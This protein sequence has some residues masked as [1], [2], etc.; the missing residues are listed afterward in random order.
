[1]KRILLQII[2]A[3]GV[4]LFSSCS[5]EP[6]LI[7]MGLD[8]VYYLPRMKAYTLSPAFTGE[9]YRW[10]LKTSSGRD[11]L[12][13]TE[14][15]Y[16]F[17]QAEEGTYH[18]TFEL[19]DP[20]F[21]DRHEF[22]VV[23]LHEEVEYSPYISRV[24][25][26][27]PAPGQ[28]VNLMPPYE[29]RDTEADMRRKAEEYISGNWKERNEDNEEVEK[30][31]VSLGG[32][33]GYITF[34]FDHTVVNVKGEKDFMIAGNA[35]YDLQGSTVTGGSAEPGIVKVAFDKNRN[36]IPD[37]DEWYELAGSEYHNSATLKNY[38]IIYSRPDPNKK[39]VPG[40]GMIDAEYIAWKDNRGAAGYIPQNI[41]HAQDY[42]PQWIQEEQLVCSGT[43]L[44]PNG[45]L[46]SGTYI[47]YPYEWGYAD[48]HPN[49]NEEL[50][51]FDIDWAVDKEGKSVWLP[52]IDFVRVYTGVN[53]YNVRVGETS[54]EILGAQDLHL[55]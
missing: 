32:Y 13:S 7:S 44:P 29:E 21:P 15:S 37:P 30:G 39:P 1:M 26:Y 3:A 18:L 4:S 25:E 53:Q 46:Q 48:N 27:R 24:Y 51:S 14:H 9:S 43:L 6:P 23:V 41:S 28:F 38:E 12:L 35:F 8:H 45:I 2:A 16:T 52:G 47:Q 40:L 19:I 42:Y 55:K 11:S 17:L 33:G 34:G 22:R 5:Q 31:L 20:E 10:T 49:E 36:G 54:T 50:N